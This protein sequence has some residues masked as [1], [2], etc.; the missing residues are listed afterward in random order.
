MNKKKRK[1]FE[2][3]VTPHLQSLFGAGIRLTRNASDAEDLVQ[4]TVLR[5][6][7]FW[8]SFENGTNARAWLFRILHNTF[9]TGYH[10]KK[11]S[12]E[13][14]EAANQEQKNIDGVL[15]QTQS[16]AHQ[17]PDQIAEASTLSAEVEEALFS[18]PEDFRMVVV[19][20]DMQGFSY[21]EI[22]DITN[23]PIGTVMSRLS[24]GRKALKKRLYDY[25]VSE[26]LFSASQEKTISLAS[27]RKNL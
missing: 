2:K 5:A 22:A 19:L 6:F 9:V 11:R 21:K 16:L 14:I 27:R 25:A 23:V 20:C 1:Q 3:S 17:R 4:E 24:R 26:G 7:R 10:K 18:L 8:D 12:R 13:V 15:I